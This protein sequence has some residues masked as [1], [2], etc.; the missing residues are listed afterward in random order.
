MKTLFQD[1]QYGFRAL[2]KH[3]GFTVVAV[4]TF[5]LGLGVNIALFAVFDVFVLEPLPLKDP[6]S[7]VVFE[8]TDAEGHHQ[9]L[10]S[11]LDYLEYRKQKN[12]ISDLIAWNKITATLGQ[13]PPN[14]SDSSTLAEGYVHLFGQMVSG[15]YFNVLGA[16][17]HLG[18]GFAPDED[19]R[20]GEKPVLVLS[21]GG[22]QRHFNSD[23][24]IVGK[25]VVLSGQPFVVIGVTSKGFAGTTPD[26]PSFW[27][28]LMMRDSLIRAGGWGH[29]IWFTDRNTEV[30]TFLGRLAPGI[31]R[32]Q[33]EAALQLTT[34]QLAQSYPSPNRKTSV[35]LERGGTFFYVDRELMPL[36]TPLLIGFGLVLLIA[37]AN[38]ANLLLAR[39]AG[40]QK[41]IGVRLALG[42]GRFRIVRQLLTESILLSLAGG[43]AA[44][45]AAVWTLSS[46]Y[47]IVLS[48][49]PLP[50][51]LA[52]GFSISFTPNWR[53]FLFTLCIAAVAGITAGLVPALQASK[54]DVITSLKEEGAAL[55]AHLRRSRMRSG[56]VI[57]QVAVCFSLLVSAGLLVKNARQMQSADT[58]MSTANVFS[59]AVGLNESST[60]ASSRL[61]DARRDLAQSISAMPH[62][63]AV[64]EALNQPLSGEMGNRLVSLTGEAEPR[65]VRFNYVSADY[66]STLS[67]PIIRGR[68]FTTQEVNSRAP[69]IVISEA[70]AQR[71]WPGTEPVGQRIGLE[72][73]QY[74]VI[75]VTRDTRSRWL[76]EKD[77]TF[78]YVPFA[79]ATS[80]RYLLV[81]TRN[82]PTSVMGSIREIGMSLDPA[83]RTVVRRID[84]DLAFHTAPFRAIA[85]LSSALGILALIL[86]SVGLYGVMSFVVARQTREIGIRVA[87]GATPVDVIRMFLLYGGR[88]IGIGLAAGLAIGAAISRLLATV[89]I[90]LS[91]LD[92]ITFGAVSLFLALVGV[93]AI[94]IP[95]WRGTK[96]DP[97]EALRY[98]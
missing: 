54:P 88:L 48:A 40:R 44:V 1:V 76:W 25:T 19:E 17:M 38:V 15:N 22:W 80:S 93:L 85:W 47:P 83:L 71:F 30:V 62:V 67:I 52:E 66:F 87:L 86:A 45:I 4:L 56:L 61:A 50:K 3:R 65:E 79:T 20:A 89:L 5:A 82:D 12:V 24:A 95:A 73:Q 6:D 49:F 43:V 13:A 94:F 16:Q 23:P 35:R 69:V 36:I 92:P 27:A 63:V 41:E 91:P 98:E 51:D 21:Y 31:S 10:F 7:L 34:S 64:S 53:V 68:A 78:L 11:Y 42:A 46:L 60:V 57:A 96:A 97:L 33:A 77:Q 90:D 2:R 39:A 9:R 32:R 75:G 84:D 18:R 70:T 81:R 72:N 59:V 8:G 74:E 37:C 26:V 58:G 14:S 29:K 55:G 28:P